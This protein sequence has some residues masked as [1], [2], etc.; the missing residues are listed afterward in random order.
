MVIT[1]NRVRLKTNVVQWVE[2]KTVRVP[3]QYWKSIHL[4]NRFSRPWKIF[5]FFQNVHKVWKFQIQ[6]FVYSNF[7]LLLLMTVLQIFF[8]LCS[9]N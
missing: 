2:H 5:E 4:W 1:T 8:S 6:P 9:M 7:I 3:T